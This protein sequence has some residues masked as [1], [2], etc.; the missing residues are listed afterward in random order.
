MARRS[1]TSGAR[2]ARDSPRHWGA[3]NAAR[4]E[5]IFRTNVQAAYNAGRFAELSRPAMRA[6]RPFWKYVAILDGRTTA[7][8]APLQ[9]TVRPHDDD[10][11]RTHWPPLHFNCRSTVVSLSRAEAARAGGATPVPKAAAPGEGFGTRPALAGEALRP[12]KKTSEGTKRAY[13]DRGAPP[14]PTDPQSGGGDDEDP[15]PTTESVRARILEITGLSDAVM[16]PALRLRHFE[17]LPNF[18]DSPDGFDLSPEAL[19]EYFPGTAHLYLNGGRGSDTW[20]QPY[21]GAYNL[22]TVARSRFEACVRTGIHELGHHVRQFIGGDLR[23]ELRS[24][25]DQAAESW[26]AI[27]RRS[28]EDEEEFF[29]EAFLAYFSHPAE[30]RAG[31]HN[32]YALIELSLERVRQ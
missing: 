8:C 6:V 5:T 25:W 27:S 22:S 16:R 4:L 29:A 14:P 11:W 3:P 28:L 2:W 32:A 1:T 30:L 17:V 9:G 19:G 18:N 23:Q 10:F 20:G 7:T 12:T 15:I 26:H 21:D 31:H 24:L 13:A